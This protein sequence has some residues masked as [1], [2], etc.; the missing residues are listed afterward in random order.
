[1]QKVS[2]GTSSRVLRL[3]CVLRV[4]ADTGILERCVLFPET[5]S[6][7]RQCFMFLTV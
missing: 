2:A 4:N 1:M 3:L 6:Q 5:V 7:L